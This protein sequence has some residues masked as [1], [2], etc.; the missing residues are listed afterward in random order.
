[1]APS[2]AAQPA[3]SSDVVAGSASMPLH[4]L[5]FNDMER[6]RMSQVIA[7]GDA[8]LINVHVDE[9]LDRLAARNLQFGSAAAVPELDHRPA[10]ERIENV[11][12]RAMAQRGLPYV[13]GGGDFYGPTR[14][15][16]WGWETGL[17]GFDCSGLVRYAFA[18]EGFI[19]EHF[20]HLQYLEG[21]QVP[22]AER[23]RGDL[24]F[25]ESNGHQHH[26][27]IYLGGGMMV[28]AKQSGVPVL[29]SPVRMGGLSPNAVRLID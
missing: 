20:A 9:Q 21:R 5:P 26:V 1:M 4:A 23:Q 10:A 13:W 15:E 27:A 6:T 22:V 29:V 19:L 16:D 2:V 8:R 24:L 28:E 18:D 25:W 3:A 11:I 14:G 7:S 17:T 12:N